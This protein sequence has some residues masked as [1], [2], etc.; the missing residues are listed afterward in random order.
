MIG[1]KRVLREELTR[2]RVEM[3]ELRIKGKVVLER[4]LSSGREQRV[5]RDHPFPVSLGPGFGAGREVGGRRARSTGQGG[6]ERV[7]VVET[8]CSISWRPP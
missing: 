7:S 4:P 2:E 6:A 8:M 5:G 1:T 3:T